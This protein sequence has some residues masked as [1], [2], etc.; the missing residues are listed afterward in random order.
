MTA[1]CDTTIWSWPFDSFEELPTSAPSLDVS[2]WASRDDVSD[3][4]EPFP[5]ES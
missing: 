4:R 3:S 2:I 1:Q 5:G